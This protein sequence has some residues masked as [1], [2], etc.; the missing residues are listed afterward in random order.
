M[1]GFNHYKDEKEAALR[2]I[3]IP[4]I[5]NKSALR[6]VEC[7]GS[8]V[9]ALCMPETEVTALLGAGTAEK[10]LRG[11]EAI[12]LNNNMN[13]LQKLEM[14]FVSFT[15]ADYPER[16]RHIPDPP[17]GLYVKGGLPQEGIPTVAIIGARACSEYGK[18]IAY[19][20]GKKLGAWGVQVISGM[21]RGID[22]IAQRGTLDGGGRT[23]AVLGC[24]AD[25]CYPPENEQ[26]YL[27][28]PQN[29]GVLSEYA[30]GTEPKNNLFPARNR[31][32]SGL[33]DVILV[34]E[35]RKRSGT[36]ITVMQALEQNKEVYAVP[37]RITDA[38]SDGCNYLLTQGAGVAVSPEMILRELENKY[39]RNWSLKAVGTG[40]K[41][42]DGQF[43]TDTGGWQPSEPP[44]IA[45]EGRV[46]TLV[47]SCLDMTPLDIE[48]IYE[49]MNRETAV[50]MQELMVILTKLQM[51][52]KVE[53]SGNYYRLSLAL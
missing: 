7:A 18:T 53:S 19:T 16:L 12:T 23:Y 34:V 20:F 42:N 27:D 1:K 17:F 48:T 6:L 22:G 15:M 10:F 3:S 5:G 8:A 40:T 28:I 44:D 33:A 45:G 9:E 41:R 32:I 47:L 14:D 37:G 35:A 24:G 25:Y 46:E 2:L 13:K 21:A 51:H 29:G 4:G 50:T 52:G 49:K 30:P 36:Y 43:E 38:L 11:R 31:I 39:Y 26:L